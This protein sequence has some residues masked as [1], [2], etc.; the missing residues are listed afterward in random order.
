MN[1][2][3]PIPPR[4]GAPAQ[5]SLFDD[6]PPA[7]A[8]EPALTL[9]AIPTP[10]AG[11]SKAQ[12]AFNR[13]VEQIG[14]Q[15]EALA[16]WQQYELR[17]HQRLA[18]ELQPLQARL[19]EARRALLTLMDE[20]LCAPDAKPRLTKA[21]RRKLAAWIP[22]LAGML[23]A[24]GPDAGIEAIFDR[25]A[26]VAHADLRQ[27]E[28]AEAEAM[29]GHLLGEDLIE[30]HQAQSLDEL[31]QHAARNMA[32]RAAA[33][34]AAQA[35]AQ[36]QAAQPSQASPQSPR[37]RQAEAARQRRDDA[38]QQASQS[39]REVFRKLA[40]LLHP[41]R[42]TDAA[43]RARK[44]LL[45]Q[46]ANQAYQ[47]DDLLTL[48]TLQLQTEQIDGQHLA[49]LPDAR[50][51]HYN[52]V[53]REQLRVLQQEVQACTE[54]YRMALGRTG[55]SLS[56]AAVDTVLAQDI[57]ML[58]QGLQ[59]LAI[60][61]AALRDPAKRRAAIDALDLPQAYEQDDEAPDA[62]DLML[63]MDALGGASPSPGRRKKR[64]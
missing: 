16:L 55:R 9:V 18:T 49:G 25:H 57:A 54:P 39:V 14:Q 2:P 63:L 52:Q 27:A 56:P 50:L 32:D 40:S 12:R 53:L 35:H 29:F 36:A 60:D 30:G 20:L 34:Q 44:T 11:Q 3:K 46:Q 41:D 43:E 5:P 4:H 22:E 13:L 17:Y 62:F 42:E 33:Q 15:R 24:D 38:A 64:R 47:A 59:F 10:V 21:Q 23:L 31:M 8:A 48:L 7:A 61:T 58:Q 19:H 28:L 45:M 6:L 37:G 26:D 51:N 1:Q